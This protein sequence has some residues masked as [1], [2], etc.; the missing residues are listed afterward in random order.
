M[1]GGWVEVGILVDGERESAVVR[2][3]VRYFCN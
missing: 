2:F 3:G 1:F